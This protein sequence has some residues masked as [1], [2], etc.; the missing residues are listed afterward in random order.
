MSAGREIGYR[1]RVATQDKRDWV[2]VVDGVLVKTDRFLDRFR[3]TPRRRLEV[4]PQPLVPADPF[5]VA[6]APK[7]ED[8]PLG[9]PNLV[10]QIYGKRSC[11]ETA[12]TV[13]YL[14]ERS[15]VPRMIDLEEPD[16][17]A[18]EN[19]LVRETK[20][21]ATP[22]VYVRGKYVGGLEELAKHH[23]AGALER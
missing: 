13:T 3:K 10:V 5:T 15:I 1:S 17:A 8:K 2:D 12:R 19:R 7:V 23:R 11:D 20:R 22:W 6:P 9:D 18:L 21:Y 4:V 16:N 14:R